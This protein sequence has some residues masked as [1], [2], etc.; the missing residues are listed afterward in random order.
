MYQF[1]NVPSRL[2]MTTRSPL[3]IEVSTIP[4]NNIKES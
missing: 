2:S 4:K 3:E 1:E